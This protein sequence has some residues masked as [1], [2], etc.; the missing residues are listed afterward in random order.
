LGYRHIIDVFFITTIT[1]STLFLLLVT[2]L[3]I[4]KIGDK[5]KVKEKKRDII[6]LKI[7][8]FDLKIGS[9]IDIGKFL[10]SITI[11][12]VILFLIFSVI[13]LIQVFFFTEFFAGF[14]LIIFGF[15]GTIIMVPLLFKST[16]HIRMATINSK[17]KIK[18][19]SLHQ[20]QEIMALDESNRDYN[21]IY[22]IHD[23]YKRVDD[24]HDWPFNP[25]STRKIV[26]FIF[27]GFLP[28][29]LSLFGL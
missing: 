9:L 10:V 18:E 1:T 22:Q 13:G 12:T 21:K 16:A 25:M 29:I 15:I 6:P 2:F 11:P 4:Y 27:S 23:L 7:H 14:L 3:C 26:A 20:I 24:V 8:Y 19:Q 17:M 5:D 28:L